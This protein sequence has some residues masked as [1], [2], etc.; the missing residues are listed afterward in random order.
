MLRERC[1]LYPC[2]VRV[3]QHRSEH[4]RQKKSYIFEGKKDTFP[5][6]LS[7]PSSQE[8]KSWAN[9]QSRVLKSPEGGRLVWTEELLG[10]SPNST[11]LFPVGVR[12]SEGTHT[13]LTGRWM[14]RWLPAC[15]CYAEVGRTISC[16]PK[17]YTTFWDFASRIFRRECNWIQT[18]YEVSAETEPN[19]ERKF[20]SFVTRF[21]NIWGCFCI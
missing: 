17:P 1:S 15:E 12:P 18:L 14:G 3:S 11:K 16:R 19:W 21:R 7:F 13:L 5:S 10:F 4:G 6:N 9:E 2:R 8:R 20:S